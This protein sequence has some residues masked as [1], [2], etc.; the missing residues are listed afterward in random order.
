MQRILNSTVTEFDI[1]V[2]HIDFNIDQCDCFFT[3]WLEESRS[4]VE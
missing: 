2:E 4:M 3:L 1:V